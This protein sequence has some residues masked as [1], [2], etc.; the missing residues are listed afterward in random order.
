MARTQRVTHCLYAGLVGYGQLCLRGS[1]ST[2]ALKQQRL[3]RL[4]ARQ[5]T[6]HYPKVRHCACAEDMKHPSPPTCRRCRACASNR[7][8]PS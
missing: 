1:G 2:D 5:T 3:L 4:I 8:A 6:P 7:A